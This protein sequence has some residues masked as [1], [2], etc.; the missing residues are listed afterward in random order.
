MGL[1]DEFQDKPGAKDL[2][3]QSR[4]AYGEVLNSGSNTASDSQFAKT[5]NGFADKDDTNE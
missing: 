2:K 5:T 4:P 3:Q 1:L